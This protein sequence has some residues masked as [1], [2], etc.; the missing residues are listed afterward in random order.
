MNDEVSR[1]RRMQLGRLMLEKQY[2]LLFRDI[3]L[4]RVNGGDLKIDL[5]MF[6]QTGDFA[7]NPT[8]NNEDVIIFPSFNLEYNFVSISGAVKK[9]GKYY[10]VNGDNLS[11]LLILANGLNPAYENVTEAEISRLTYDGKKEEVI[12]VKI[13]EHYKLN[14]GDRVKV[15]AEETYRRDYSVYVFGEVK[16]PGL[17][18]VTKES[19]KLSELLAKAGGVLDETAGT[20]AIIYRS[21]DLSAI[22]LDKQYN[23]N[24]EQSGQVQKLQSGLLEQLNR[25]EN[26]LFLRT[27]NLTED[28][29]PYFTIE[30]WLKT[31]L[32]QDRVSLKN[33]LDSTSDAGKF[34]IKN[35]DHIYVPPVEKYIHVFGQVSEPGRVRFIP[36][37]D[38][39]YYISQ[40][41]GISDLAR[42]DIML[43]TGETKEWIPVKD[44]NVTL[45]AGDYIFV[46]K[47]VLHTFP[48]FVDLASKYSAIIGGIATTLLLIIQVSKK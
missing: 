19:H 16:N 27:S 23:W 40:C 9:S 28:D 47:K 26:S 41:R 46:P 7:Y 38:V 20:N 5:A 21:N 6:Y 36:G 22:F 34:L 25:V 43:I 17:I 11:T 15:L 30:T 18:S 42:E 4:K 37:K 48:Y 14:C 33:Y 31:I 39:S 12:R 29:I 10:F 24:T 8:L 45:H 32:D 13:N 3:K 35:G 2:P 1:F 44:R